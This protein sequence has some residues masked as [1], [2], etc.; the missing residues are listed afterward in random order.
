MTDD[1]IIDGILDRE[2]QGVPPYDDLRDPGGR[3]S[4]GI[5]EKAHPELWKPGPPTRE[6]ARVC[7]FAQY[8][9]P[10][11]FIIHACSDD[12]LRV[13]CIDF[14]VNSGVGTAVKALQRVLGVPDDGD[15]GPAT[16]SVLVRS[17][18]RQVNN[19]LIVERLKVEEGAIAASP[20][21]RVFEHGW[22]VRVL[23]F[24]IAG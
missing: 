6:Q 14:G 19:L 13:Q 5:S 9:T 21:E 4:W 16:V 1:V 24:Y 11:D 7:Y 17:M 2:K 12:R 23:S 18:V 10:F 15:A 3:T 22:I 8:V 20:T